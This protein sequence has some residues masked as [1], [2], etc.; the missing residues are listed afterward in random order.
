MAATE[1][2][3]SANYVNPADVY[4]EPLKMGILFL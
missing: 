3:L 2:V 1:T 4:L